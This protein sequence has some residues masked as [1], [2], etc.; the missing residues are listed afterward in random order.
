MKILKRTAAL[1]MAAG[2]VIFT[3]LSAFAAEVIDTDRHITLALHYQFEG[4]PLVGAEFSIY[5]AASIDEYGKLTT[6]EEFSKY[7]VNIDAD[8]DDD[9]WLTLASTLEGFVLRDKLVPTDSKKTNRQGVAIFPS[10]G[11]K[12]TPGLYLVLGTRHTQDEVVYESLPFMILMPMQN[13]GE[14]EWN[15][16]V[17]LS[18]KY[19]SR[20]EY[21]TA[22]VTCKVLKVWD[23]KG[24]E[25]SRPKDVV[26]QLLRDGEIYDTVKLNAENNWRYKW[27]NLDIT[28]QW[29]VVE[30][31]LDD[32]TVE[33][34][35]EGV[36]FVITN[37]YTKET[38]DEPVT[39]TEPSKPDTPDNPTNP[40]TPDNPSNPATPNNPGN[41]NNPANPGNPN[42]PTLPQTGQLWWPVPMLSA[43]GVLLLVIGLLCFRGKN[44]EES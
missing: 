24:N 18:P 1:L 23:D 7:N 25:E 6:T 30:K 12:L 15:Y 16:D 39:T 20:S 36:T 14:D 27:S 5:K 21:E 3:A 11:V 19:E 38:P 29:R 9:E 40:E 37:T 35:R 8:N 17:A 31:E 13:P 43:A 10:E 42:G 33:V 28:Y 4:T 32:Y 2:L 34:S 26:V 44:N 41:P 22:K